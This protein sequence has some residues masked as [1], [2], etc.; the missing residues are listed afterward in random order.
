MGQG[1]YIYAN[2]DTYTGGFKDGL[3]HGE[4]VLNKSN[5]EVQAG[6]WANGQFKSPAKVIPKV[7]PIDT[8]KPNSSSAKERRGG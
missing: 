3:F 8:G 4:G 7:R 1:T 5:G 2:G 6:V